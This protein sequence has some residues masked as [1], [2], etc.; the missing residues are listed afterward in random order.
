MGAI[1][2]G[3]IEIDATKNPKRLSMNFT[4]GPDKDNTTRGIYERVADS[5]ALCLAT[6]GGP[7]P[8]TFATAPVTPEILV[9]RP[10][11]TTFVGTISAASGA[12]V[13]R[14]HTYGLIRFAR[15]VNSRYCARFSNGTSRRNWRAP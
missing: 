1:Y 2:G 13:R 10:S 14:R 6:T 9:R 5:W 7:A 11:A 4:D 3:T 8:K 15:H 12:G